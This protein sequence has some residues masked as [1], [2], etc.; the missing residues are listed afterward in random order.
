M[1]DY[2]VYPKSYV[3]K[4]LVFRPRKEQDKIEVQDEFPRRWKEE[5]KSPV[6]DQL[7]YDKL[8]EAEIEKLKNQIEPVSLGESR[9]VKQS[10][11]DYTW[12]VHSPGKTHKESSP[13][14]SS[15][16][17]AVDVFKRP[18]KSHTMTFKVPLFN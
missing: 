4:Q 18:M 6:K 9:N 12:S 13:E 7:F 16:L 14:Q 5:A 11:Q 15:H 1:Q 10:V 2:Q 17:S 3:K 8:D